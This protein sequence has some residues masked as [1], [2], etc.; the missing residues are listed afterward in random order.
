LYFSFFLNGHTTT[1][2]LLAHYSF[3]LRLLFAERMSDDY[4]SNDGKRFSIEEENIADLTSVI[5]EF[6]DGDDNPKKLPIKKLKGS[7][8]D[9]AKSN[10]DEGCMKIYIRVRP[11]TKSDMTMKILSD[12]SIAAC[13]PEESKRALYTKMEE[14]VYVRYIVYSQYCNLTCISVVS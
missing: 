8:D 4:V 5:A 12:V 10:S 7:F 9:V 13:A 6:P 3:H 2:N 11:S 14:R 1:P